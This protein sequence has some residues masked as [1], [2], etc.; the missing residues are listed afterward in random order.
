MDA[1]KGLTLD[2]KVI[3]GK[4]K[5]LTVTDQEAAEM[6]G[7]PPMPLLSAGT[8]KSVE[9]LLEKVG[10]AGAIPFTVAPAGFE[11]LGRW[12]TAI[13]PLLILIGFVAIYIE[14]KTPGIGIPAL[15]A[16]ICFAVYFFG[17]YAA[18]LA[19]WEDVALFALGITLLVVEVFF[20]PGFGIT[21]VLGLALILVGLVMGMTQRLPGGPI[22][23]SWK[24]LQVPVIKVGV[25]FV[26]SIVAMLVLARWLPETAFFK[27]LELATTSPAPPPPV[28]Q[29][30]LQVGTVGVAETMLRPSGKG[31]FEGALLDVVTQG[32]MIEKDAMIRI[33]EAQGSRVVVARLN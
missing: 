5:L 18:G 2:G 24:E 25:G 9:E 30:T 15:V 11:V 6:F 21:G 7:K 29:P 27:R 16:A 20:L 12:I 22:L 13:S 14:I 26:G 32:D 33:I 31:R 4:G 3:V 8:V 1:D 28:R 10:L 19:G 17:H 23:P